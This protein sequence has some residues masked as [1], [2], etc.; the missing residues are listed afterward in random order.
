MAIFT[1]AQNPRGLARIIR[2]ALPLLD[3]DHLGSGEAMAHPLF[4]PEN[5]LEELLS[6]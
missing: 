4:F 6:L 5:E 2:R 1:P 3:I